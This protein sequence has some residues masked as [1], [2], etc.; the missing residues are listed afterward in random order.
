MPLQITRA[1]PC[2][3]P[4]IVRLNGVVQDLHARLDPAQFRSDWDAAELAADWRARLAEPG[5]KVALARIDG[6]VEG[7]MWFVAQDRP[8]DALHHHR[9]RIYV[10][11][12]AVSEQARG[13]GVGARLLAEAEREARRLGI[14]SVVLD[15]WAANAGAQVFFERAG[16]APVSVGRRKAIAQG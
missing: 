1:L 13:A 2:D 7:Y 11:H 6:R 15:A 12:I 16:Y 9:R 14:G 3:I 5:G 8:R 4:D 10:H